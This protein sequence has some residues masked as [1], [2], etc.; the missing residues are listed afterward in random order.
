MPVALFHFVQARVARKF[1]SFAAVHRGGRPAAHSI[2]DCGRLLGFGGLA[3]A[4][5]LSVAIAAAEAN[6]T[7]EEQKWDFGKV[8]AHDRNIIKKA[9][10]RV[11]E[12]SDGIVASYSMGACS[13]FLA[14][15]RK[16]RTGKDE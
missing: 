4:T 9:K 12:P 10:V 8:K 15:Q 14:S 6:D 3:V 2:R 1:L 5:G 11:I 7:M 13:V 16:C